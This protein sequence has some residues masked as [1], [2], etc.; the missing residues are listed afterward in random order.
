[1]V[2]LSLGYVIVLTFLHLS[3]IKTGLYDDVYTD[4]GYENYAE[5]ID[6]IPGTPVAMPM[7]TLVNIGYLAV[8]LYWLR[9]FI[10]LKDFYG[11]SFSWYSIVYSIIQL[12]RILLQTQESAVLDQW[13]TTTIF[14]HVLIWIASTH[15]SA[16]I[17]TN[18]V[19]A[20][21]NKL[22][23]LLSLISYSLSL[24]FTLGF[25]ASLTV[26][27]LLVIGAVLEVQLSHGNSDT[28]NSLVK[29]LICCA[30]F[31]VLKVADLPLREFWTPNCISGHFL[32]KICDIG[33]IYYAAQFSYSLKNYSSRKT[34]FNKE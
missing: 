25:D 33:Q 29:A 20:L 6:S 34:I 8:G 7:N 19:Q 31:V 23:I 32:S 10:P 27:I 24:F 22:V 17:I 11:E 2:S 15:C 30:G 18:A 5:R 14:S 1:M 26:H 16:G 4:L 3:I 21:G 13:I 12:S 28:M 9:V